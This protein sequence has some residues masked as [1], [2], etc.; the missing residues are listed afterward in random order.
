MVLL[1]GGSIQACFA[2]L[3]AWMQIRVML[4]PVFRLHGD[5]GVGRLDRCLGDSGVIDDVDLDLPAPG[6][7][8]LTRPSVIRSCK[9]APP[10]VDM[11]NV[12]KWILLPIFDRHSSL[13]KERVPG[14]SR[15]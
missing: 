12:H 7:P 10:N 8:S 11:L 9:E 14:S 4:V 13:H 1:N 15:T 5:C 3:T 2:Y 6:L